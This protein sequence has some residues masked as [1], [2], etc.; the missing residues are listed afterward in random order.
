M[1]TET[2]GELEHLI[3]LA[4]LRLGPEAYGVTITEEL[5]RHTSRPILRPSIYVALRRLKTKGLIKERLGEPESRRGGRARRFFELEEG[6]LEIVRE[7]R[8]T[9]MSLWDGLAS[10]LDTPR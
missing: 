5:E 4:I 7:S 8:S 10:E 6:G 3:L 1:A 2:I 9:L